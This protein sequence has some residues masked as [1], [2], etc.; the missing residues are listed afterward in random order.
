[1]TH[2]VLTVVHVAPPG[3]AVAVNPVM[4]LWPSFHGVIQL[5]ATPLYW[6]LALTDVGGEGTLGVYVLVIDAVPS[7]ERSTKIPLPRARVH[8]YP[9]G[10]TCEVQ[11][12][13]SG[14]VITWGVPPVATAT[15]F[16]PVKT[17]LLQLALFP[18]D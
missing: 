14:D 15:K 7:I 13:P 4:A 6:R 10:A 2:E 9:D 17:I 1:M 8:Q 5:T 3:E 12:K 11:V 16:D 18:G